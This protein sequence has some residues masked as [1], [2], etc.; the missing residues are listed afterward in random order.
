MNRFIATKKLEGRS[1]KTLKYYKNTVDKMLL[2]I[3]KNVKAITTDDLR[4]YLTDYQSR[5]TVSKQSV[6]N[7]RRNLSSFFTCLEDENYIMK[8]PVRRI[9]KIKTTTAVKE[10]YSDD[11]M[12]D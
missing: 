11:E 2:S 7:V 1:D 10:T 12:E 5:S 4:T 8:S 9:R 3:D 6:D